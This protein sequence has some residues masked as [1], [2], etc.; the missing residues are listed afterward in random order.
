M[1]VAVIGGGISG[2]ACVYRLAKAEAG[3]NVTLFEANSYFGG[4][5]NTVDVTLDGITHG[6]DTSF[7]VFNHRTYPNLVKL[8][9]ELDVWNSTSPPP[10][11]ICRSPYR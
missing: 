5:T 6:V 10:R 1:K 9:E 7:L 11:P 4:H 2:L 8:F 3:I